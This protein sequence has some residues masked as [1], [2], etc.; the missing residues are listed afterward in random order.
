[1]QKF[2]ET[3]WK[4]TKLDKLINLLTLVSVLHNAAML[5]RDVGETIGELASN[6]LATVG[7]KDETGSQLDINELVSTSVRDF[8]QTI[9]GEDVYEDVSKAWQKS[10]RIVSSAAMIVY[11]VRG[12]HDTSKDVMEWTAENTGKIGN[13]LKRWGVVG[14]RAYPWMSERVKAQDAYRRKFER[15]TAGLESLE[16][17]ASSLSQVTGDVRDIQEEYSELQEQRDAFTVLVK[18]TASGAIP[19]S[20]PQN[21]PIL[22][23]ENLK[24][25]LSESAEAV[26][27]DAQK[28]N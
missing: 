8:V 20:S 7:I 24:E 28:G 18:D 16:D 15:V 6:M 23:D 2:A 25:A 27:A 10:S 19:P 22:Y 4:N 13:A 1:M 5:S 14:E 12:L 17:A 11:T 21:E 3:A 9:V 26:I